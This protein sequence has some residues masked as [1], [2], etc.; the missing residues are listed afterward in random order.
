[1]VD[2]TGLTDRYNFEI[3]WTP[4]GRMPGGE[5]GGAAPPAAGGTGAAADPSGLTFF[6]AAEKQ[7]GVKFDSQKRPMQ[8]IVIDKASPLVAEQ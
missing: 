2:E 7:L 4:R 3:S 8:V 6:E 5:R 1:V